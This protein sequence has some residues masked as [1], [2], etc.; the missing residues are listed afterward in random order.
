[1]GLYQ[2]IPPGWKYS[3]QVTVIH[4]EPGQYCAL[5]SFFTDV[6]SLL[7]LN[8]NN[9]EIVIRYK[10]LTDVYVYKHPVE[11][12]QVYSI[13]LQSRYQGM[14]L[15]V[16]QWKFTVHINGVEVFQQT[17]QNLQLLNKVKY[18]IAVNDSCTATIVN[19]EFT[20]FEEGMLS[21]FNIVFLKYYLHSIQ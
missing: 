17:V 16:N 12:N 18:Q 6:V 20:M 1:M 7:T 21:Y 9:G 3:L 19:P 2:I 11:Y 10:P 15:N 14:F 13:E 4:G 8:F 5:I